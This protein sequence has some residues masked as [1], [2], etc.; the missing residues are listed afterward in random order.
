M[1]PGRRETA[2]YDAEE[3]LAERWPE[4]RVHRTDLGGVPE[5]IS[6]E[7]RLLLIDPT[8]WPEGEA[9]AVAHCLAHLDLDHHL[10]GTFTA[11]QEEMADYLAQVRL[12]RIT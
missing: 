9:F 4:W 1:E 11:E 7:E 5:V 10:S 3:D 8:A 2:R 12:D 6:G